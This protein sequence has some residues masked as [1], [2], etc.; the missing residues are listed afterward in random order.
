LLTLLT[1]ASL[2]SE[3][4]SKKDENSRRNAAIARPIA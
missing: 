4:T 2:R 3:K 1:I